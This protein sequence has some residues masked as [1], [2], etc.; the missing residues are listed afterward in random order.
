MDPVL[1]IAVVSVLLGALIAILF[2]GSYFG[3]RKSEVQSITKPELQSNPKKQTKPHQL[4]KSHAK[5][6]S[7]SAT[8]KV[9]YLIFDPFNSLFGSRETKGGKLKIKN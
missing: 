7:H 1:I 6:H 9:N 5:A 2:F 3:K 8:D 4:R